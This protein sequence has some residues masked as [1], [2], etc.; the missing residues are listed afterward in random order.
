MSLLAIIAAVLNLLAAS[1]L[2]LTQD[3]KLSQQDGRLDRLGCG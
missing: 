1:L 3:L 2:H